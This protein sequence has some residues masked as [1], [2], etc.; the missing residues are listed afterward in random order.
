MQP[1]DVYMRGGSKV[2]VS[3]I[4]SRFLFFCL[5]FASYLNITYDFFN[6]R[7]RA[8][9]ALTPHGPSVLLYSSRSSFYDNADPVPWALGTLHRF[10]LPFFFVM[11]LV[12][13]FTA[14][15]IV[16]QNVATRTGSHLAFFTR[17]RRASSHTTWASL[18]SCCVARINFCSICPFLL[19]KYIRAAALGLY[20]L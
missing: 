14:M 1:D 16:C 17:L 2:N 7:E 20:Y 18:H 8:I 12:Y 6:S 5:F 15:Y 4:Y 9:L 13:L 3:S 11:T 10:M 19:Y